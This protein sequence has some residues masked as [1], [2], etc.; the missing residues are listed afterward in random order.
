MGKYD[1]IKAFLFFLVILVFIFGGFILMKKSTYSNSTNQSSIDTEIVSDIRLDESKDYIYYSDVEEIAHELDVEFKTIN[2]NFK[3]KNDIA[4]MLN[5]ETIQLK[6]TL[7]YD[8]A[9]I[10]APY[11]HLVSVKYKIYSVYTYGNYLSLVVDYYEYQY[12]T[13]VSYLSTKTYVFDKNTGELIPTDKLLSTYNLTKD[14]VLNK[15]KA[16]IEDE[17]IAKS[18]EQ[19]DSAATVDRI[20]ELPLF[21]DKIGR[22]SISILVKSD[23]KDYNEVII[24]S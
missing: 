4:K 22:L 17:D 10:D 21:V 1:N 2:L 3:D 5:D 6:Q 18:E 12:E 24:L 16:H 20:T 19:L 11:D 7:T 8:D 9:I 23:Q 15:I 14:V 13:L